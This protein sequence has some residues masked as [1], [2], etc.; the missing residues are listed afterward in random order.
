MDTLRE[1]AHD[2]VDDLADSQIKGLLMM[3]GNFDS[4]IPI[5]ELLEAF[6]EVDEMEA[7]PERYK[8]YT[9]IDEMMR[10]LLG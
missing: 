5:E 4:E 8:G 2:L 9:D 10:D 7:H 6:A 1:M 3:F